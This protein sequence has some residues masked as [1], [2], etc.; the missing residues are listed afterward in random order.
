[1]SFQLRHE[2]T[3]EEVVRM[4]VDKD[5]EGLSYIPIFVGPKAFQFMLKNG[6]ISTAGG[7]ASSSIRIFNY[8]A[9]ADAELG[10]YVTS[11]G[12]I[13]DQTGKDRDPEDILSLKKAKS[14]YEVH[15]LAD[16]WWEKVHQLAKE[17]GIEQPDG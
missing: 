16:L 8:G 11:E 4:L 3:D 15:H 7:M 14:G 6:L 2:T 5:R 13:T 9:L 1:M 17:M 12:K 10:F